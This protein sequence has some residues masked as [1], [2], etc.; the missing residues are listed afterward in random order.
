MHNARLVAAREFLEN[1]HTKTFWLGIISMPILLGLSF[2]IPTWLDKTQEARRYV[3]VDESGWLLRAVD[4]RA[5]GPDMAKVLAAVL[6]IHHDGDEALDELPPVLQ[7]L[8]PE[9]AALEEEVGE[10]A[11]DMALEAAGEAFARPDAMG[12][13]VAFRDAVLMFRDEVAEWWRALPPGEAADL[14]EGLSR[15]R[16]VRIEPAELGEDPTAELSRMVADEAI[17]AYF[18]IGP[19]PVGG[20]EGCRYVSN[21]LTDTGLRDWFLGLADAEVRARRIDKEGIDP[22]VAARI[23]E[24]LR[25]ESRQVT[26]EGIEEEV[27]AED[28]ARQLAP[29][30]FVYVLWIAVFTVAQMLLANTVEEKSNRT[31]EV[32]LSSVSATDLMGGKI[33][34]IAA[35]GL[36]M[37]GSWVLFVLAAVSIV[38]AWL[39]WE[40][41]SWLGSVARDPVYLGQFALYFILGY[42]FYA[43]LLVALGSLCT[44]LKEAQNLM[45]PVFIVLIVPLLTMLPIGRDP[46]GTLATVMTWIPPFTPFV[47]MNRAALPPSAAEYAGTTL[48]MVASIWAAFRG[49]GRVFQV[50]VLRYGKPPRILE[51]LRWLRHPTI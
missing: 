47:M 29:V 42:L 11:L 38:P 8:A 10:D 20:S 1:I 48:L 21:N 26:D 28:F 41:P 50:G 24:S 6:E 7:A 3:V 2:T 22:D 39:G 12:L 30:A 13:P 4:E 17:F 45:Y 37:L 14:A 15:S 36:T 40:L 35:T 5:Q 27:V 19:D 9:L 18:V 32:L 31:I 25:F 34:G 49:A 44:S 51:V 43:A 16:Y 46:S 23:Q 33:L